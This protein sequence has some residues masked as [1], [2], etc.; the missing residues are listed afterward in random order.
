MG[1]KKGLLLINSVVQLV[2]TSLLVI[3]LI[4]CGGGGSSAPDDT[5][6]NAFN[7]SAVTDVALSTVVESDT[8]TVAGIDAAS[9]I[10][11]VGGEFSIAGGAYT[12]V[13]STVTVGQSVTLRQ[14]SSDTY[15]TTTEAVLTIGGVSGIFSVTT[16]NDTTPDEFSF[17]DVTGAMLNTEYESNA[18]IVAGIDA[19]TTITITGGEYSID[20][21]AYGSAEG[22]VINGQSVKVKQ[23]SSINYST[24]TEAILTIGG[25]SGNYVVSTIDDTSPDAF[26][27][28]EQTE[29]APSTLVESNTITIAGINVA[30]TISISGGEY[31]VSGGD[32]TSAE[33]SVENGQAITVR[34]TTTN[35]FET[36]NSAV[37]TV[38]N[39]EAVF[40]VTTEG[41]YNFEGFAGVALNARLQTSIQQ[42]NDI[43]DSTPVSIENGEYSIDKGVFTDEPGFINNGQ[44]I[45]VRT[46]AGSNYNESTQARLVVGTSWGIFKVTTKEHGRFISVWKTDNSGINADNQIQLPLSINGE[47]DFTVDWGD[48]TSD[49]I[50]AW[51]QAESLHTYPAVGEYTVTITGNIKGLSFSKGSSSDA[52]KLIEI[53]HWGS[54]L[55]GDNNGD[56][57]SNFGNAENLVLT[58]TDALDLTGATNLSALFGGSDS[59]NGDVSNWDTSEI[60]EMKYLFRYSPAFNGD[61][62]RWDVSQVTD[63]SGLFDNAVNFN[64]DLSQWMFQVL[65]V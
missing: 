44:T 60:T 64:G 47:Y 20:D 11:I 24:S 65:P 3:G 17:T 30:T 23:T 12:N 42:V 2:F 31:S 59:F 10:S 52:Y 19:E 53:S 25:F 45:R 34:L 15:S 56:Y 62:S 57:V 29:V 37:L 13:T 7:F 63:M 1:T 46:I 33:G 58:A 41:K 6:P 51:D 35:E 32:Y 22:T 27:F 48:D 36:V 16:L 54:F 9:S 8:I 40:T 61:V 21:G 39:V 50:T 14:T 18:I 5:T 28:T 4:A 49:V 38:G 55:L 43:N 26:A